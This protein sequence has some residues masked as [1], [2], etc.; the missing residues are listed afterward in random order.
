MADERAWRKSSYSGVNGNCVEVSL[1]SWRTS[2][3][4]GTNANCVEVSDLPG[5]SAVRDS[6]HPQDA[7]LPFPSTEWA[8]FVA[9]LVRT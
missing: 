2:S 9:G 6:R 1:A 3:Y 5:S 4:S 8:A 7:V